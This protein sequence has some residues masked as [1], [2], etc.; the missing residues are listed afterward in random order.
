M[1]DWQKVLDNHGYV[2]AILMDL[3]NAFDCLPHDLLIAKLKAYGLSPDILKLICCYLSG[4]SQQIRMG[5]NTSSWESLTKGVPQGSILGPLLFNV[6]INDLFYVVDKC[7]M[8]NFADDNTLTFTHQNLNV[9]KKVLEEESP[10]LI[11][12]FTSSFMKLILI[13]FKHFV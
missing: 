9:L 3:S 11:Q 6:F 13:N 2:A 7:S 12:W 10:S 4:R 1:K 5:S 8:Y